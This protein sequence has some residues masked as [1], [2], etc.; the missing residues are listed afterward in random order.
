MTTTVGWGGGR[1]RKERAP[2]RGGGKEVMLG[3]GRLNMKLVPLIGQWRTCQTSEIPYSVV[4]VVHSAFQ[5][6]GPRKWLEH[7]LAQQGID[8]GR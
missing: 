3:Q 5:L 7:T 8:G 1:E 6:L 4:L 2:G